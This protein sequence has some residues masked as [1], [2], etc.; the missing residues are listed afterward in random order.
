[1]KPFF[2]QTYFFWTITRFVFITAVLV[3]LVIL[4]PKTLSGVEVLIDMATLCYIGLMIYN[5]IIELQ[6][7]TSS[8]ITK[9]I[10]GTISILI[11][12]VIFL[13]A[14]SYSSANVLLALFF[15]PWIALLGVF[16]L[17]VRNRQEEEPDSM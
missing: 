9:Y 1:M 5:T 10:I 6:N 12:I 13:V 15:V 7:K 16:D 17:T 11:G 3:D 2:L 14:M 8:P 4:F